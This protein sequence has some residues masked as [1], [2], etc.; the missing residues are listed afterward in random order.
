MRRRVGAFVG[1]L[2][3]V[4]ALPAS[5]ALAQPEA[6]LEGRAVLPADTF[7]EGPQ[8][9]NKLDEKTEGSCQDLYHERLQRFSKRNRLWR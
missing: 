9:G 6:T 4:A 1:L 8:S 3:A 2:V 5:N 7:A